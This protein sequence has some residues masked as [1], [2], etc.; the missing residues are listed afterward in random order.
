MWSCKQGTQWEGQEPVRKVSTQTVPIQLQYKG[1]FDL[2]KGVFISNEIEGARLNGVARSNDSL[3]TVLIAPENT[4]I[5]VSPWFAFKIWSETES[6]IHIKL[7]YP[8]NAGHRYF[9]KLSLDG[10]DLNRDWADF[11]QPETAAIKDFM[12]RKTSG[13]GSKF[14]ATK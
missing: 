2:G 6:K 1:I 12:I 9:P 14:N 13:K 5:N 3:I 11:N 7:T 10:V 4:P 8:E